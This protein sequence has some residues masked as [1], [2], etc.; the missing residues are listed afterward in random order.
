MSVYVTGPTIRALREKRGFTQ[1]ELAEKLSVSDKAISKWETGRG[2]PDVTLLEP[3]ARTLGVSVAELLSG[4]CVVNR[5]RS[6]NL[7]RSSFYVCPVCGNVLWAAGQGVF[8]CCGVTLPPLE[9][10]KPDDEHE[11]LIEKIDG[12]HYVHV[13]HPMEREHFICFFAYVTTDRVELVRLYP[14][15]EAETRFRMSG[16]GRLYACCNRHGLFEVKIG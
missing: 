7:L 10:E 5:N 11:I 3:L 16:P 14:E 9:P 6:A 15:M 4:E 13:R 12:E 8:S 2:L 1:K